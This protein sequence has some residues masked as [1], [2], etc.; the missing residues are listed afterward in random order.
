M[1]KIISVAIILLLFSITMGCEKEKEVLKEDYLEL[2]L[3]NLSEYINDN[4]EKMSRE[5]ADKLL[6]Y[7]EDM[8]IKEISSFGN[9]NSKEFTEELRS[10]GYKLERVEGDFF[11][12]I[13]YTFYNSYF[14]FISQDLKEYFSIMIIESEQVPAKDAA[15]VIDKEEIFT[16]ALRQES[17]LFNYPNSQRKE[18]V[19][20]LL[21]KYIYFIYYGLDN[22]PLFDFYSEKMK[23]EDIIKYLKFTKENQESPLIK[24]L[25]VFIDI[26]EKNNYTLDSTSKEYREAII[27][28]LES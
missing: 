16:R 1:N 10:I 13:D 24:D 3:V 8:Q 23:E 14:Q 19:E 4:I 11:P 15:L 17:F 7:F 26:I 25:S 20:Q 6:L 28:G 21:N 12:V 9:K 22:T 18:E 2:S 27:P 5:D